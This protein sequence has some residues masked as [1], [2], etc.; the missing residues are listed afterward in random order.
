ML[1]NLFLSLCVW[2]VVWTI[3]FHILKYIHCSDILAASMATILA[4]IVDREL[5]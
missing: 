5:V 2:I 4:M 3:G 1:K